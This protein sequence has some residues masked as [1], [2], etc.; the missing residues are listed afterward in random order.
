MNRSITLTLALALLFSPIANAVNVVTSIKPLQLIT[1]E[2]TKGISQPELLISSTA[3][4]HD[5]ALKPSDIK[6]A[7]TADLMIWFGPQLEVFLEKVMQNRDNSL[8]LSIIPEIE[9][10]QVASHS[11]AANEPHD[12]HE[13]EES[14]HDDDLL[15]V[16]PHIWLGPTQAQQTAKVIVNKLSLIDPANA[17]QYKQNYQEFVAELK[18]HSDAIKAKLAPY[19]SMGYFVF[20]D[21][22][23]YYESYFSLN[24]L[25]YFTLSPERKAGAKTLLQIRAAV[26]NG[27]ANCVFSEPQFAPAMVQAVTRGSD[28]AMAELDPLATNIEVK[29][30]GYFAFLNQLTENY[31]GCLSN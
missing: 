12:E 30:G 16:D 9:F 13:D 1:L 3:S 21:A 2:I 11:H 5:Y 27:D 22:Y 26:Q 31:I 6:K 14:H 10:H 4:P 29:L 19:A 8:Q 7:R 20:H 18:T 24:K 23:G 15:S 17:L 28:V 25:G